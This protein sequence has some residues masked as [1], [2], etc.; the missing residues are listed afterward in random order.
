MTIDSPTSTALN[1]QA[2]MHTLS[3]VLAELH[4]LLTSALAAGKE[5]KSTP[6]PTKGSFLHVTTATSP[7]NGCKGIVTT[8][9][10]A[11]AA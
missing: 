10:E 3:S 2:N 4:S 7:S 9:M 8:I 6:R 5:Q 11:E 1:E